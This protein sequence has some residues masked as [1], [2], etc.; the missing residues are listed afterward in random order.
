L[1]NFS[2]DQ[3]KAELEKRGAKVSS[4]ISKKTSFLI[5]GENP[6]SKLTEAERL[7]VRTLNEKQM[8]DLLEGKTH[9]EEL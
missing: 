8:V 2:R 1:E 6:G 7:G 3:A 4:S 5:L 9:L